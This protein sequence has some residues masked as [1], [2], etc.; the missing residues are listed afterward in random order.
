MGAIL[1]VATEFKDSG[2]SGAPR[3][4]KA[5]LKE[6]MRPIGEWMKRDKM[7]NNKTITKDEFRTTFSEWLKE[8]HVT[9]GG[10]VAD[11]KMEKAMLKKYKMSAEN[12]NLLDEYKTDQFQKN[13]HHDRL[14]FNCEYLKE[15]KSTLQINTKDDDYD[16]T[17]HG[18]LNPEAQ[19]WSPTSY[20]EYGHI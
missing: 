14:V 4:N 16:H 18:T 17:K 7:I 5:E 11:E 10:I 20:P 2:S 8:Y 19:P 13:G 15:H 9:N 1:Y 12:V 3:I 6:L